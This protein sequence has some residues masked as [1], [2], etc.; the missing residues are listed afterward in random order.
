MYVDSYAL[1]SQ[2]D[3]DGGDSLHREGMYAFGQW[4]HYDAGD[5]TV[6]ISEPPARRNPAALI[7][8]FEVRPGIYVRHPDPTKWTSN[9]DTTS[10]DQ[11]VPLIAYCGAYEDYSRLWRLF[12]AVA[13]RGMFAQN[14]LP[15]GGDPNATKVPDTLIGHLGLFIRA[16]G[17]WTAPL[18][19]LL[20][21]TDSLDLLSTFFELLPLHWEER[22]KS[23]RGRELRDVDDN[24]AIIAHLLAARFKPTVISWFNR[25]VYALTRPVNLGNTILGESNNVMGALAWYH[26]AEGGG[27]P[28]IAELYRPIIEEYFSPNDSYTTGVRR[29]TRW[30]DRFTDQVMVGANAF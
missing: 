20:F 3:G 5:N 4:L 21:V 16:G 2:Q 24:N 22:T 1:I 12:K 10:R 11:I 9:P 15:I 25:Q 27:N 28:E 19:P 17:Y 29:V 18:Y 23:L 7:A 13:F 30:L 8:K 6:Y 26:R 14:I